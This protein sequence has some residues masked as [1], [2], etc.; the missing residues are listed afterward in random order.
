MINFFPFLLYYLD[1]K[2][3]IGIVIS[4]ILVLIVVF[5]VVPTCEIH[6]TKP[7]QEN[8][9]W[10]EMIDDSKYLNEI[11]IP[12]THN[13]GAQY[14][15]LSLFTKCQWDTIQT[16]LEEGYRYL[17]I[18]LA[19]K[20]DE[21]ILCHGDMTCYK[22]NI[23][24]S[25]VLTLDEVV[26]ECISFL[27]TNP[28]ETILFVVK[29]DSDSLST[30]KL[31]SLLDKKIQEKED[32]WLLTNSIPALK[33]A[34][35]KI[36][37][38]RRY[39]DV[40]NLKDRSGIDL[41]WQDQEDANVNQ[42]YI[43]Q[44][45]G[46]NVQDYYHASRQDKWN[47]FEKALME[48]P[49]EGININFLSTSGTYSV[50]H[51][52][53]YANELNTKFLNLDLENL[54]SQW[55][56]TDFGTETIAKHIYQNNFSNVVPAIN[57]NEHEGYDLVDIIKDYLFDQFTFLSITI[58]L[59][60]VMTR[61]K[62]LGTENVNSIIV[63]VSIALLLSIVDYFET[64]M[65]VGSEYSIWRVIYSAI[66]YS[67]RPAAVVGVMTM[68]WKNKK[69][70]MA[71]NV[72]VVL[73]ALVYATSLFSPLT[74]SFSANNDFIRGP[75]GYTSH[76]LSII[77][78]V[79]TA[80]GTIQETRK[81]RTGRDRIVIALCALICVLSAV[82]STIG[83]IKNNLNITIVIACTFYYLYLH[84][85]TTSHDINTG[86]L[87][88]QMFYDDFIKQEAN[89]TAMIMLDMNDLKTVNDQQG[90]LAGDVALRTIANTIKTCVEKK[91]FCYRIGGDEFTVLCLGLS[92]EDVKQIID[93]I[94]KENKKTS[95][96]CSIG[97]AMKRKME[98]IEELIRQADS[99]MYEEK[100][101]YH[102]KHDRR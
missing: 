91:G 59:L 74:F 41:C 20:D 30:E 43:S 33:E 57:L 80:F 4:I 2:K 53:Y 89:I 76:I 79:M 6:A 55:I 77:L 56:L 45:N 49:Q 96:S 17:D 24:M 83:W 51:P 7:P 16:Q 5:K 31:Q 73:N 21:L 52:Y 88:R 34:R 19:L 50:G 64:M 101:E 27:E 86:L 58:L 60:I 39:D 9:T 3:R 47:A 85:Q 84:I 36:V 12:G 63:T 67:L 65:S 98:S 71:A 10:M 94:R 48:M 38:F 90:H 15:S 81:N 54:N 37:L 44:G 78:I 69:V 97:Y 26:D 1:M 11:F 29:S 99:M 95:Y 18:R 102:T 8:S 22:N 87:N 62:V 42:A 35:G 70:I 40:L 93:R 23:W 100:K 14:A 75:L 68:A 82:L 13:S 46:L 66:G 25:G 92:E 32:Q 28:S 61:Y 72:T